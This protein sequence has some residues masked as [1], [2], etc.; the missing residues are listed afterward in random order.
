MSLRRRRRHQ[1]EI[2][3]H[4]RW[5]IS[6]ADFITLLFAFFVTL[7]SISTVDQK[8]LEKAMTAFHQAFAEWRPADPNDT[9]SPPGAPGR[10]VNP[11]LPAPDLAGQGDLIQVRLRLTERLEALGETRV[12]LHLDPRGLVISVREAASFAVGRAELDPEARRLFHEIGVTLADLPNAVRVEGHTDDVP[13]HTQRYAS[14]WELSTARATSVVAYFVQQVG[15]APDR[16]SA[17]GYAEHHPQVPN[18]SDAARARNRRVDVVVLNPQT[19]DREEP[20]AGARME[21]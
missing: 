9:L 5:L 6:Y 15:L 20:R 13:I 17:A 14:N 11:A 10:A 8:K 21:S 7:Y 18:D 2:A 12:G 3:N 1:P 4:E 16:L 19:R